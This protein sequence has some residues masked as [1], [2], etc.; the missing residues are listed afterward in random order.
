MTNPTYIRA[1]ATA[2]RLLAKFGQD[3][4]LRQVPDGTYD[5]ST[6]TTSTPDPVDTIR[7][8]AIFD[9]GSGVTQERG[10][11]VKADDKELLLESGVQPL[12]SH[13]VLVNAVEYV[14]ISIGEINPGG[15]SIMFT[16]HL[17]K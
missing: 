2:A 4:T 7:K 15:T 9:F 6:G 11:L 12:M 1:A 5:P 3:V 16:L 14:I 8:G 13:S 17:R 10:N